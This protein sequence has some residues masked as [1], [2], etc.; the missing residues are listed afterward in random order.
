MD[1]T[2]LPKPIQSVANNRNSGIE[3]GLSLR[4]ADFTSQCLRVSTRTTYD[5]RLLH[6]TRWCREKEID[7]SKASL[8]EIAD[9]LIYLY[10]KKLSIS[11]IKG[12][13]SAIGVIHNGFPNGESVSSS[14]MLMRLMKSFFLNKPNRKMLSPTWSLPKVLQALARPPYEPMQEATLKE[15]TI[16]TFFLVEA[17]SGQR[18]SSIHALSSETGHLCW[19]KN[20][21]RLLPRAR[22][23]AKNQHEASPSLEIVLPS[24]S[25]LSSVPED[26]LWCP[27]R[28]LKCHVHRTRELRSSRQLFVSYQ[29]PH[30]AVSRDSIS[31]WIVTAIKAGGQ[32]ALFADK[33]QA[34]DTQ[35][36]AASWALFNR[37]FH[38][39]HHEGGILG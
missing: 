10:D 30:G 31:R 7:P 19:E 35:G 21:V 16:K 15:L 8:G 25:S 9:F 22:F 27:V 29:A 37:G 20:K 13:R 36:L 1:N 24:I 14:I 4:A 34:H 5:S 33:I 3:A 11:T 26:R 28:A 39:K 32:E 23:L 12:Y 18:Q 38:G 2:V 17:S 6:Y